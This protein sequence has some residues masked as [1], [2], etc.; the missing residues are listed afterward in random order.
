MTKL[1]EEKEAWHKKETELT[2]YIQQAAQDREQIIH[3]YTTYCKQLTGQI[4]T[5]TEQVNLKAEEN[6]GLSARET[7][8]V[9]HVS[10]LEEQL[11]QLI[12]HRQKQEVLQ[13]SETPNMKSSADFERLKSVLEQ[14]EQELNASIQEKAA[15]ETSLRNLVRTKVFIS[16]FLSVL[17]VP[18]LN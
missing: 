12:Q 3:Q 2:A 13:K 8:L 6:S 14:K 9:I 17:T 5:L 15:A 1:K 18:K 11:Q 10:Q 7:Q 4:E 16:N